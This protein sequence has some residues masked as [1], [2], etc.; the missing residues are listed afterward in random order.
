MEATKKE[1][2]P[3]TAKRISKLVVDIVCWIFFAFAL[4][5]TVFAFTAQNSA[6][7]YP[8][9]GG[10][11]W[12]TVESDSMEGDHGF[13]VGDLIV[14]K[15]LPDKDSKDSAK[16]EERYTTMLNLKATEYDTDGSVKSYGDVITFWKD[17]NQDG[18]LELNS[19]R[20]ERVF[21]SEVNPGHIEFQ[22]KGDN[23][24]TRDPY[25]VLDDS[26]IG[27]WTG[28]RIGGLGSF[29]KFLQPPHVGFF[30]CIILPLAGFLAYEVVILIL[31][32]RKMKGKDKKVISAAEEELIKQ[33][34]IEEFLAKQ[35]AEKASKD[36]EDK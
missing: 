29:I 22:T 11:A 3:W 2:K 1:K 5:F 4:V 28:T 33:K 13:K 32:I 18:V 6:A 8:T 10:K 9:F 36:K 35:E 31:T 24:T 19:H 26:V 30:V 34:A 27:V 12:L 7:K 14:C 23:C 15:L 25:T 16:I 20:I 17:I 21:V